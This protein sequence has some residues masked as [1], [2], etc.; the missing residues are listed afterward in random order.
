M[1]EFN[2]NLRKDVFDIH[3][4]SNGAPCSLKQENVVENPVPVKETDL[5][6]DSHG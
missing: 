5:C 4:N 3:F 1:L 2:E 6:C